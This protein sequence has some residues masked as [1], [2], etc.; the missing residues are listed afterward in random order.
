MLTPPPPSSNP[1]QPDRRKRATVILERNGTLLLTVS[2]KG[3]VLLPGGGIHAHELP[4]A[5]AARELYE[6]TGLEAT[7]LT[8]LFLHESSRNFHWV[9]QAVAP[10]EP[11]AGDDA[12]QLMFLDRPA[13]ESVHNL[14]PATRAILAEYEAL[15][16]STT[17]P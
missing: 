9:Y 13:T 15:G 6:E 7:C 12:H 4:I 14:S 2:R 11:V 16:L 5:A 3:L 10:G 8:L 1:E 17:G